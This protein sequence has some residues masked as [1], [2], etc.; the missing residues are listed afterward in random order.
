MITFGKPVTRFKR[1]AEVFTPYK[2]VN[3]MIDKFPLE[4][5]QDGKTFIDIACGDG[6]FLVWV[7]FRKIQSNQEPLSALKT[8]YGVELMEDN[9][10]EC[11]VR[12]L[13]AVSYFQPL[14][15]EHIRTVCGNIV[16]C[17]ALAYDFTFE[18]VPEEQLKEFT[19]NL[20]MLLMQAKVP[21]TI[22][23]YSKR[24]IFQQAF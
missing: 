9:A 14:T 3:R 5:W 21:A 22:S 16:C 7:L 24:W 8:V 18:T 4:A 17:D 19:Q 11:R 23:R 15:D 10:F 1:N 13:K 2:L 12:L 20:P 6:E